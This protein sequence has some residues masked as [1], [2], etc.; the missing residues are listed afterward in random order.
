MSN[1]MLLLGAGA[2][3]EAQIPDAKKMAKAIIKEFNADSNL[4]EEAKVL[5]FVNEQLIVAEQKKYGDP[6]IDCVDIEALY[7]AVLL[8]SERET[9]EISPFVE[10]WNPELAKIK[11]ADKIFKSIM[12]W[13][14]LKLEDLTSIKDKQSVDYL[15]P[16]KPVA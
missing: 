8:L 11:D 1:E 4:V 3:I 14:A 7:N 2:S 9:L 13:M 10:S 12:L 16:I 6:T 5:N 15:K